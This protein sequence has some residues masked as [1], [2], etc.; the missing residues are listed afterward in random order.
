MKMDGYWDLHISNVLKCFN[1]LVFSVFLRTVIKFPSPV[2][3]WDS[4]Q[5][6]KIISTY[7][8]RWNC[9]FFFLVGASLVHRGLD[10]GA[11]S[12]G[13]VWFWYLITFLIKAKPE[14]VEL[15][16]NEIKRNIA[17]PNLNLCSSA[18]CLLPFV[19]MLMMICRLRTV[20]FLHLHPMNSCFG[21][22]A[23]TYYNLCRNNTF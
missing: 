4:F 8:S 11:G 22:C 7:E 3:V 5:V 16:N 13:A 20:F 1:T 18:F 12:L 6:F 23:V 10:P 14:Y 17:A 2:T 9:G 19:M 21:C 15:V